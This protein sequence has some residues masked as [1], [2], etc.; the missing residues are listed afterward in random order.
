MTLSDSL[1]S[2][3]SREL[4]RLPTD[5]LRETRARRQAEYE[6]IKALGMPFNL[7]RGKPATEQVALYR[8][9]VAPQ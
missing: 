7:A 3:D 8:M 1:T 6:V 4:A 5:A 9:P 2:P